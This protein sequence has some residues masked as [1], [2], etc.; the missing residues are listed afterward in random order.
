LAGAT[1]TVVESADAYVAMALRLAHDRSFRAAVRA[2]IEAGAVR[3]FA[4]RTHVDSL[5]DA[6]RRFASA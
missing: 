2:R 1:D 3:I 4:D 5:A 6:L